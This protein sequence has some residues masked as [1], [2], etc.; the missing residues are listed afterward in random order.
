[1]DGFKHSAVASFHALHETT[2]QLVI[3][4]LSRSGIHYTK[5]PMITCRKHEETYRT[6]IQRTVKSYYILS[7]CFGFEL[8]TDMS[9]KNYI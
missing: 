5:H 8:L 4:Y 3:P 7:L 9:L 6:G 2:L 1:M